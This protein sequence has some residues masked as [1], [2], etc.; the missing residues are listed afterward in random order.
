[1]THAIL[2]RTPLSLLLQVLGRPLR[3][4]R[5]EWHDSQPDS[6]GFPSEAPKPNPDYPDW[7]GY[8]PEIQ[9]LLR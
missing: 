2:P 7:L 4:A 3:T 9:R 1:M 8:T 6:I 5:H